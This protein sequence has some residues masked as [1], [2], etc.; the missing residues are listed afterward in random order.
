M[1]SM[2]KLS[3]GI[4]TK[5]IV[6]CQIYFYVIYYGLLHLQ[7]EWIMDDSYPPKDWPPKGEIAF[8]RFAARYRDGLDVAIKDVSA[9]IRPGERV[10]A[11][12]G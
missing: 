1:R 12:I 8:E 7:A 11:L 3:V 10:R 6:S 2:R 4:N 9:T 5:A